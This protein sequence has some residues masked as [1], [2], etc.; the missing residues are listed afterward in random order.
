M[1]IKDIPKPVGTWCQHARPGKGCAIHADPSRPEVCGAFH[2]LWILHPELPDELK[3]ERTRVVLT[4]ARGSAETTLIAYCDPS[5]P[6]A[7]RKG[8]M[9][10]FLTRHTRTPEGRPRVVIVWAGRR[11]WLLTPGAEHD[12]GEV[13]GR[14]SFRIEPGPDGKPVARLV[15]AGPAPND[16]DQV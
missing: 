10:G 3:P 1:P 14:K 13:S 11:M 5:D 15:E 16:L 6:T 9:H 4:S 7:W 2:C 8:A 12:M